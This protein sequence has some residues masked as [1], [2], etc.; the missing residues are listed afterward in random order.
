MPS[1][2]LDYWEPKFRRNVERDALNEAKLRELGWDSLVIWECEIGDK[3]KLQH[4]IRQFL[5]SSS[6]IIT[7]AQESSS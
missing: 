7:L 4:R 6:L 2:N 3:A 5:E 1:C